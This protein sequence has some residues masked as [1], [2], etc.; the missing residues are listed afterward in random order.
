MPL[1]SV[2][3]TKGAAYALRG[4]VYLFNRQW[5][6]AISDF[7]EIVYN[8]TNNYGYS[9]HPDYNGIRFASITVIIVPK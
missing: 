4:K 6:K 1:T 3:F 2:E 8:K 9:L 7:E 5:D